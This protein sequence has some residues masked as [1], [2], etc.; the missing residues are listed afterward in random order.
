MELDHL[1]IDQLRPR[2]VAH[3]E[4]VPCPGGGV[5]GYIVD[6][7]PPA[8]CKHRGVGRK[9][10]GAPVPVE[11][12]RTGD[13]PVLVRYEV[14]DR[15]LLVELRIRRVQAVEE[16][17]DQ[18]VARPVPGVAGPGEP[19]PP[20]RPLRHLAI[21]GDVEDR[22]P[23]D[24]VVHSFRRFMDQRVHECRVVEVRPALQRVLTVD[25]DRVRLTE[26]GVEAALCHRRAPALAGNGLGD[27]DNA[28]VPGGLDRSPHPGA[29]A[30]DNQHVRVHTL[31]YKHLI[32]R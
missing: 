31:V 24:E 25:V 2:P 20:E 10:D 1:H 3:G 5:R 14:D 27:Q 32:S 9:E 17:H 18:L 19:L 29:A 16:G 26:D 8:G 21:L 13:C 23:P 7:G 30:S 6:L 11:S 15:D 28:A 4:S 22:T 12:D